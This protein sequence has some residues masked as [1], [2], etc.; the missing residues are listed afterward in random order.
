MTDMNVPQEDGGSY[1]S[2]GH[3]PGQNVAHVTGPK[4]AQ[5]KQDHESKVQ[6]QDPTLHSIDNM[7]D[8]DDLSIIQE[9]LEEVAEQ[10]PQNRQPNRWVEKAADLVARFGRQASTDSIL[11]EYAIRFSNDLNADR[12]E[13]EDEH[14]YVPMA[15]AAYLEDTALIRGI[16]KAACHAASEQLAGL[17]AA[18][19]VPL[20]IQQYRPVYRGLWPAIPALSAGT[21][22]LAR[23]L[24][25]TPSTRSLIMDLPKLLSVTL[26]H[27]ARF[28]SRR[29]VITSEI[30]S[31]VFAE[32][33]HMWLI[34]RMRSNRSSKNMP[35][36]QEE[37]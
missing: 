29:R 16:L 30:A 2:N 21:E 13:T 31:S 10:H 32:Q 22:V 17:H 12:S 24:Y 9:A 19:S 6:H 35:G 33:T 25:R 28:V 36:D 14:S 7:D 1:K 18:L 27:L 20:I 4:G 26:D 23:F 3:K 11:K 5:V 8:A 34:S 15:S 37:W